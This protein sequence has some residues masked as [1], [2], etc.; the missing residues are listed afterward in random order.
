VF[1]RDLRAVAAFSGVVESPRATLG[2]P[3]SVPKT[4]PQGVVALGSVGG[5]PWGLWRLA[6]VSKERFVVTDAFDNGRECLEIV[7]SWR[8]TRVPPQPCIPT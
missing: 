7:S 8:Q 4:Y 6:L 2:Y 1:A 5:L 3:A